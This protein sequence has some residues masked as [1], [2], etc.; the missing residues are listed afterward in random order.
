[1]TTGGRPAEDGGHKA[2]NLSLDETTRNGLRKIKDRKGDDSVSKYVEQKLKPILEAEDPGPA[3]PTIG[4]VN[5]VLLKGIGDA[6]ADGKFD[7]VA[8]L[9]SMRHTLDGSITLCQFTEESSNMEDS[10]KNGFR[11]LNPSTIQHHRIG[12]KVPN[13]DAPLPRLESGDKIVDGCPIA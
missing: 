1:M 6:L 4:E 7:A 13:M 10:H 2:V 11:L 3:C 8:S 5:K 12:S 9:S